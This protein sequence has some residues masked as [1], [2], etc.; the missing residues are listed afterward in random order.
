MPSTSPTSLAGA[1]SAC[2]AELCRIVASAGQGIWKGRHPLVA[3]LAPLIATRL[4]RLAARFRSL[5]AR[6]EAGTLTAPKPR[7]RTQAAPDAERPA[8]PKDPLP[9]AATPG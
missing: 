1:V 4:Y 6:Y 9:P 7:T 8:R 5:V 3:P 2:L